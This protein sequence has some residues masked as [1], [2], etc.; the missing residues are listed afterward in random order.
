[1]LKDAFRLHY[2]VGIAEIDRDHWFLL[3]C[4]AEINYLI[5]K[6]EK[7]EAYE[8]ILILRKGLSK[9]F[10][11]EERLMDLAAFPYKE[12]HKADH[13]RGLASLDRIYNN[14]T[15]LGYSGKNYLTDFEVEM[16]RHL[17]HMDMQYVSYVQ[18]WLKVNK[19][20]KVDIA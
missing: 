11:C 14:F 2:C 1:M 13:L 17:D 5:E 20:V 12:A 7:Q 6:D 19:E 18:A 9:H 16:M 3:E 15:S 4:I 8:K 10:E